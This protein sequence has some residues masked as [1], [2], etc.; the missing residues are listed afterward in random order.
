MPLT[1]RDAATTL[2]LTAVVLVFYAYLSGTEL[3]VIGDTRGAIL[4]IGALGLGMCIVGGREDS[5]RQ[6]RYTVVQSALG[7]VSLAIVVVGLITAY[8]WLVTLLTFVI[9]VMWAA[10]LIRRLSVGPVHS[11]TGA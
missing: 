4:V 2:L 5:M 10:A 7:V 6:G 1:R 11:P 9:T 3:A 8:A